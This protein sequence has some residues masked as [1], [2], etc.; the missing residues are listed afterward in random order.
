M[1]A[2]K[3]LNLTSV[4]PSHP[5]RDWSLVLTIVIS[6]LCVLKAKLPLRLTDDK[7]PYLPN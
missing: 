5:S 3:R 6:H 4:I 7:Q 1:M 2:I